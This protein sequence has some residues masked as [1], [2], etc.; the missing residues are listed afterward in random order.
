MTK[1]RLT[2]LIVAES[3]TQSNK[4]KSANRFGK[5]IFTAAEFLAWTEG[6][7]L[8][9]EGSHL[10]STPDRSGHTEVQI[11]NMFQSVRQQDPYSAV[12]SSR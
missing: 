3:G 7:H 8:I 12:L 9:P 10:H 2:A 11:L 5:P 6:K 4:A 1:S